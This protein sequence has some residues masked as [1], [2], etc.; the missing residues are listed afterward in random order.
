MKMTMHINQIKGVKK[1]KAYE[2]DRRMT[3]LEKLMRRS[4]AQE[5]VYLSRQR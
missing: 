4:P 3:E 1:V 2:K 5:R